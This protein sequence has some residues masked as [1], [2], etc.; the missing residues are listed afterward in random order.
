MLKGPFGSC[1]GCM[2]T[3]NKRLHGARACD[4]ASVQANRLQSRNKSPKFKPGA[5]SETSCILFRSI[6]SRDARN[7]SP[8]TASSVSALPT[9]APVRQRSHRSRTASKQTKR[10][11]SHSPW[12][13]RSHLEKRW[14]PRTFRVRAAAG[15]E[16][17]STAPVSAQVDGTDT[18]IS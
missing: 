13:S 14:R 8:Q 16:Y 2:Y 18:A 15:M 7:Q 11:V 10:A 3:G 12:T 9:S 5:V 4:A 6:P 1:D 17:V